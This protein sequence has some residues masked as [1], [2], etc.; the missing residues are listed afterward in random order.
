MSSYYWQQHEALI[1]EYKTPTWDISDKRHRIH[2][3]QSLIKGNLTKL[4]FKDVMEVNPQAYAI[5]ASWRDQRKR[6]VK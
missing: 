3:S 5:N 2:S 6:K 4:L 1:K